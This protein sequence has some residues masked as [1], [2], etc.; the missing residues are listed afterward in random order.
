[1]CQE[2]SWMM[3]TTESL[4]ENWRLGNLEAIGSWSIHLSYHR[5]IECPSPRV[6]LLSRWRK[7]D[8]DL[9]LFQMQDPATGFLGFQIEE[10]LKYLERNRITQRKSDVAA[11]HHIF[12]I[13]ASLSSFILSKPRPPS[14]LGRQ[15]VSHLTR[16]LL[17][18]SGLAYHK[19]LL[20]RN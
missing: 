12:S 6:H 8:R 10:L 4:Y 5:L 13:Q 3:A 18:L 1:M 2:L 19:K 15:I 11:N 16:L 9:I 14:D 17:V 20:I 7:K